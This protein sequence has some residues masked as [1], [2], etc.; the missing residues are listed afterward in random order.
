MFLMPILL[1]GTPLLGVALPFENTN[2]EIELD[3]TSAKD[4]SKILTSEELSL[5][6]KNSCPVFAEKF[7]RG[8]GPFGFG[9]FETYDCTLNKTPVLDQKNNIKWR[10][11]I[12][13]TKQEMIF[14][15]KYLE[16]EVNLK[17]KLKFK[18]PINYDKSL[19][20]LFSDDS[21]GDLLAFGL[22]EQFPAAGSIAFHEL[23]TIKTYSTKP[24]TSKFFLK[25]KTLVFYELTLVG[26]AWMAIVRTIFHK[27]L[28]NE[29][30]DTVVQ[31]DPQ[32][33]TE[34]K[35]YSENQVYWIH[36]DRGAGAMKKQITPYIQKKIDSMNVIPERKLLLNFFDIRYGQ[37]ILKGDDFLTKSHQIGLH[38][39]QQISKSL[40][41]RV[42]YD[43]ILTTK[44]PALDRS[45]IFTSRK[46][47]FAPTFTLFR[48]LKNVH[49][50]FAPR[51][52]LYDLH[53]EF[54]PKS[55]NDFSRDVVFDYKSLY[56]FSPIIEVE[57]T[58]EH[59]LIRGRYGQVMAYQ[60]EKFNRVILMTSLGIESV[61]LLNY[62]PDSPFYRKAILSAFY[63]YD[64][65][66][67]SGVNV[68]SL[69]QS[70]ALKYG[71][72]GMGF[73]WSW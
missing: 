52:G 32:K 41:I 3:T 7:R 47:T 46:L 51:F 49:F 65:G 21:F 70:I 68:D 43:N 56:N 8:K 9:L 33:I 39:R 48:P 69:D 50:N 2:L 1:M 44:I 15:L 5:L 18:L 11:K 62:D 30:S 16:K 59:F 42:E 40:Q 13:I 12:E 24:L 57:L 73:G 28:E 63:T 23:E 17:S 29:K 54:Y 61:F 35:N 45:D 58:F 37:Q 64:N 26:D 36:H 60:R 55:E 14:T 38:L 72:A 27:R 53:F 67:I 10:L 22:L 25:I 4:L 66:V 71:I 19:F 34:A 20:D 6:W 31:W